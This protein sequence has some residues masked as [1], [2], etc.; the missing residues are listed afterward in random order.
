M[1]PGRAVDHHHD[2]P[3][4]AAA[5]PGAARYAG[6]AAGGFSLGLV[7]GGLLTAMAGGGCSSRPCCSRR[8]CWSWPYGCCR[9][10]TRPGGRGVRRRGRVT[11]TTGC[12]SRLRRWCGCRT[13]SPARPRA[14]LVAQPGA[15]RACSWWSS[16]G[17]RRRWCGSGSCATA[18]LVRAN[19]GDRAVRR[20]VLGL[21]VH[22]RAVPA[23][24]AWLVAIETGLA[25]LVVGDRRGARPDPDPEAR[26][27]FGNPP[28]IVAGLSRPWWHTRCS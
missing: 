11:L 5:Q 1:T 14:T 6:T 12:W 16:G 24:A 22:R 2:F 28:V 7:V 15:A 8:S 10:D 4:G 13:S 9:Q 17:R 18:A 21:P 3:G 20:R 27:P 23:G 26:R 25:L 19:L